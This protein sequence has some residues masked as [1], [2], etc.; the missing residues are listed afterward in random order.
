MHLFSRSQSRSGEAAKKKPEA[1]KKHTPSEHS[2]DEDS[3]GDLGDAP[4]LEDMNSAA[5]MH[6]RRE[7]ARDLAIAT[8]ASAYAF[9][10]RNYVSV[11]HFSLAKTG[12]VKKH[13]VKTKYR[14]TTPHS[15]FASSFYEIRG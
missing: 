12:F 5:A 3:E 13:S 14:K 8:N 4:F 15:L 6:E 10:S 9:E 1:A 7:Y 2:T 11:E